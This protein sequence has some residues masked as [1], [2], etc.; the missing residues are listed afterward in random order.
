MSGTTFRFGAERSY[1][2]PHAGPAPRFSESLVN[3][4]AAVL[5]GY[6][7]PRFAA[8]ED[9]AALESALAAFLYTP[10]ESNA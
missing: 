4:V 9:W 2:L 7:Y 1:P 6:G 5:V 3:S 8:L 10:Q